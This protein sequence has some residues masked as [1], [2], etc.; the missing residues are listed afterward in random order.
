MSDTCRHRSRRAVTATR[1][2]VA[3]LDDLACRRVAQRKGT[4]LNHRAP[5][6]ACSRCW[7]SSSRPATVDTKGAR[8]RMVS[9]STLSLASAS[10]WR[11]TD[12]ARRRTARTL[13]TRP[14]CPPAPRP[15][16]KS[17]RSPV[18]APPP[19][20]NRGV[21]SLSHVARPFAHGFVLCVRPRKGG[22]SGTPIV[23]RSPDFAED[24]SSSG[25]IAQITGSRM[26]GGRVSRLPLAPPPTAASRTSPIRPWPRPA[27]QPAPSRR[28]SRRRGRPS[29][30]RPALLPGPSR[31]GWTGSEPPPPRCAQRYA[32][33]SPM[34]MWGLGPPPPLLLT[35][36]TLDGD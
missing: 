14:D 31:R 11:P 22:P 1:C 4:R 2:W 30:N 7:C 36:R 34:R 24:R 15:A 3:R 13:L 20:G 28:P 5:G 10:R 12:A 33:G 18:L 27:R 6:Q 21:P 8:S 32:A 16:S 35:M 25:S 19:G 29:R 17:R 9:S 23:L 26:G